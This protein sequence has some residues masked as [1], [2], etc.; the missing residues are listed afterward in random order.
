[1]TSRPHLMLHAELHGTGTALG[2]ATE[3][4]AL[5]HTYSYAL[6]AQSPV[7]MGA[8]K[9]SVGHSEAC[10][11]QIGLLQIERAIRKSTLIGNAHLRAPSQL[12]NEH[13]L[14]S[15][16]C[17][18]PLQSRPSLGTAAAASLSSFGYSGTIAHQVLCHTTILRL[19]R[20]CQATKL[21]RSTFRWQTQ[22]SPH[23][24]ALG[25]QVDQRGIHKSEVHDTYDCPLM[26]MGLTSVGAGRLASRL[27]A[28][29]GA[30]LPS[31][32]VFEWPT[33]REI[34]SHL[35]ALC[36]SA[37]S[38]VILAIIDE[39]LSLPLLPPLWSSTSASL[40]PSAPVA[41]ADATSNGRAPVARAGATDEP[42]DITTLMLQRPL[43]IP[44]PLLQHEFTD[45]IYSPYLLDTL[46]HPE[47]YWFSVSTDFQ[48]A[49]WWFKT[50]CS[51]RA[52]VLRDPLGQWRWN[53]QRDK[54]D[55]P[56]ANSP[57]AATDL[58]NLVY[59]CLSERS[60][61][62]HHLVFDGFSLRFL[63]GQVET[64]TRHIAESDMAC[65]ADYLR[66]RT[67]SML[68]E[69]R[70]VVSAP[71]FSKEVVAANR[72]CTTYMQQTLVA[73]SSFIRLIETQ[74]KELSA[75]LAD[76]FYAIIIV[77]TLQAAE[78]T[79][80]PFLLTDNCRNAT[81]SS[82]FGMVQREYGCIF[83]YNTNDS[84]LRNVQ[85][86]VCTICG[87]PAVYRRLFSE[88]AYGEYPEQY[89]NNFD[90]MVLNFLGLQNTD[91]AGDILG[92]SPV[93]DHLPWVSQYEK[94]LEAEDTAEE[95]KFSSNLY[96]YLEGEEISV[97]GR[98]TSVNWFVG[99]VWPLA[100]EHSEERT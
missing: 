67:Q 95:F 29:T 98:G 34:A 23:A 71:L 63:S 57:R 70:K 13:L 87:L 10:S 45:R 59:Y 93:G 96:C 83:E 37:D 1:M 99:F 38:D 89:V 78:L 62:V 48:A 39:E 68:H 27:R 8:A 16:S 58:S 47:E 26:A 41:D 22:W 36:P 54:D 79:S 90:N 85:R 61:F 92:P 82:V 14:T 17:L 52:R 72:A 56:V 94:M 60:V 3:T 42:I 81:N 49:R 6:E 9:A 66:Y 77:L 40:T 73:P 53:G 33:S 11:G 25:L 21:R 50:H 20:S 88:Y 12:V 19:H 35:T 43:P 84:F 65:H 80:G 18:M 91:A 100:L 32:L 7:A 4:G 46:V 28:V 97:C 5:G 55:L 69:V 24:C 51:L 64:A 30:A 44:L 76:V 15:E 2:D 86:T 75:P 31:T 74:S